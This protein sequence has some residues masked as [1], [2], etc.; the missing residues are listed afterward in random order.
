MIDSCNVYVSMATVIYPVTVYNVC[1]VPDEFSFWI[2]PCANFIQLHRFSLKLN[3]SRNIRNIITK[4]YVNIGTTASNFVLEK[5]RTNIV[6]YTYYSWTYDTNK[7]HI[8]Y[9]HG[10]AF[11]VFCRLVN[12]LINDCYHIIVF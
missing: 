10:I 11:L 3:I 2:Y 6:L 8:Q 4:I 7:C 1:T 5:R 12:I 9:S